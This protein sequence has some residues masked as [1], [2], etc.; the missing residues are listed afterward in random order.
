MAIFR[1]TKYISSFSRFQ[2]RNFRDA[3]YINGKWVAA[4]NKATYEGATSNNCGIPYLI[5]DIYIYGINI[6]NLLLRLLRFNRRE[7]VILVVLV[8]NPANGQLLG[9]VPDMGRK[10]TEDAIQV[11]TNAFADWKNRTAKVLHYKLSAF[12]FFYFEDYLL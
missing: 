5:W 6:F 8:R 7:L 11:A 1:S 2:S 3:A 10:E 12:Y 9:R 4:D